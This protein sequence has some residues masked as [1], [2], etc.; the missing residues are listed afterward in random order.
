MKIT[1][2]NILKYYRKYCVR[3]I[4]GVLLLIAA[5]GAIFG[6]IRL[7]QKRL[8]NEDSLHNIYAKIQEGELFGQCHA[9]YVDAVGVDIFAAEK[10]SNQ[11][12]G[13]VWDENDYIYL[14]G[15]SKSYKEEVGQKLDNGETVRL[16]G[17][18]FKCTD[19]QLRAM[20]A[21]ELGN[22]VKDKG[23]TTDVLYN[24][25][26]PFELRCRDVDLADMTLNVA[27]IW[28]FVIIGVIFAGGK[29]IKDNW[30]AKSCF[31]HLDSVTESTVNRETTDAQ[32]FPAIGMY[33]CDTV[34]IGMHKGLKV[35]G[36]KDILMVFANRRRELSG[37]RSSVMIMYKNGCIYEF[38]KAK[39]GNESVDEFNRLCDIIKN[40]NEETYIGYDPEVYTRLRLEAQNMSRGVK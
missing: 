39:L 36:Y 12:Y 32:W 8:A 38:S 10:G 16:N 13:F 29:L 33:A 15:M 24:Y 9:A 31:E 5:A 3:V 4:F 7:G 35:S 22:Y 25:I 30:H 28:L 14:V 34:V 18:T 40:K 17:I 11:V 27:G 21:A 20:A 2:I 26:G 37:T 1:D 23:V 19:K 6:F